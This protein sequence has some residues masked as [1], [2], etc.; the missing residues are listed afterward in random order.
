MPTAR[1][2]ALIGMPERTWRRHQSRARAA[3]PVKGPWPRPARTRVRESVR[4]HALAHPAWGHRKVRAMVRYDGHRVSQ[5]TVLR[6]L[7]DEGLL[8]EGRAGRGHPGPGRV[9]RRQARRAGAG[10]GPS[11]RSAG[12]PGPP[13]TQERPPL[14]CPQHLARRRG[15]PERQ[16]VEPAGRLPGPRRSPRRG[17]DRLAVLPAGPRRLRQPRPGHREEDRREDP[18]DARLVSDRRDRPPRTDPA[19]VEGHLPGL[20]HHRLSSNGGTEAICEC[21]GGWSGTGWSGW[22][23]SCRPGRDSRSNWPAAAVSFR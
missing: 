18:R 20:L 6:L 12:H 17:P 4:A 10:R 16:A 7:R 8:L 22:F 2:C 9:P 15:A 5:A 19:P 1:F 14:P 21:G 11:P 13:R 3:R 23:R